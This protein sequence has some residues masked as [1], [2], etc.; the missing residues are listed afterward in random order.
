MQK[1]G[2]N[3]FDLDPVP[4]M[5]DSMSPSRNVYLA[6][7]VDDLLYRIVGA[8]QGQQRNLCACFTPEVEALILEA[9]QVWNPEGLP[10]AGSSHSA[11][12][13]RAAD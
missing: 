10:A 3:G 6:A 9:C 1:Y 2:V 5:A 7:E 13:G 4:P 11:E 12:A 8:L